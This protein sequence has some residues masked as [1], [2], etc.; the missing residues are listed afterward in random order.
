[1]NTV[2]TR[3][4]NWQ[5]NKYPTVPTAQNHLSNGWLPTDLYDAEFAVDTANKE[6]YSRI[7]T[8]IYKLTDGAYVV[9]FPTGATATTISFVHKTIYGDATTP[10]IGSFE[11]NANGARY[12]IQQK[13]YHNDTAAPKA[14]VGWVQIEQTAYVPNVL[15]IIYADW[16]GGSRVEYRIVQEFT[17]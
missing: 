15:N 10:C 9:P 13:I 17:T 16:C 4:I 1:M 14:P 7:G 2:K 12:G 3:I 6:V 5:I 11:I 8:D